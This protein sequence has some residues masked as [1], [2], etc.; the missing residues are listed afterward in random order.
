LTE[1]EVRQSG[2][3]LSA[4]AP[5][6]A[7]ALV[8]ILA[9]VLQLW[10][11]CFD[12]PFI[13]HPDEPVAINK[14]VVMLQNGDLNPRF[15]H[16]GTA[17]FYLV[18]GAQ[19]LYFLGGVVVGQF[20][21]RL[22]L[23]V[24]QGFGMGMGYIRLP[25]EVFVAR[26]VSII[27]G[28]GTVW[29]V[30]LVGRRLYHPRAGI[31]GA[32]LLAVSAVYVDQSHFAVPDASMVF[33]AFLSVF[34]A[35]RWLEGGR[36]RDSAWAGFWGGLAAATKYNA[37]S[38]IFF[39]LVTVHLLRYGRQAWRK[40]DILWA[41]GGAVAGFLLGAPSAIF[42]TTEFVEGLTFSMRHYAAGHA[43]MEGEPLLWYMRFLSSQGLLPLLALGGMV[44]GFFR[45]SR[46]GML[47]SVV[48]LAYFALISTY[49]V[50]NARTILPLFPLMAAL[51]GVALAWACEQLYRVR[52]LARPIREILILVLLIGTFVP[53]LTKVVAANRNLTAPGV[54][55]LAREWIST[56]V[57]AGKHLVSES[58]GAVLYPLEY[59]AIYLNN[60]TDHAPEWYCEEGIEYVVMSEMAHGRFFAD[61]DRYSTQVQAYTRLMGELELVHEVRGPYLSYPG[62]AVYIY[63]VPCTET[64]V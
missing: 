50:R 37:A 5:Q 54:Q 62:F 22:D 13:Y 63:R 9:V 36:R 32:A 35:V 47:L 7:L 8:L 60:A 56:H 39:T 64:N 6:L 30:Y 2:F 28:I 25:G 23:S 16:W 14:A 61:P 46:A 20:H 15:F 44:W 11:V 52:R 48:F 29:L 49:T 18:A 3:G 51:A 42:A 57:P 1:R 24:V 26:L 34:F 4:R 43:G 21:S 33:F 53:P 58:Y 10:G 59:E 38:L 41:G 17:Y 45:R 27:L 31:L 55:K 19:M 40:P 12:L